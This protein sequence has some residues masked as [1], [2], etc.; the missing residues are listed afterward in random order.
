MMATRIH[1]LKEYQLRERSSLDALLDACRICHVGIVRDGDPV[2]IPT[3]YARVA[4]TLF[5]HGSTGSYWMRQIARG[6]RLCVSVTACDA[7]I[8]AR[9]TFESS[10]QYRSAVIF[11]TAVP[12]AG[13]EKLEALEQIVEHLIPGR[14]GEV[15]DSHKTEVNRTMVLAVALTEWSL[16]R[17]SSVP[18]DK[19]VDIVGDTW[20]GTVPINWSIGPAIPSPDLR[21]DV[22]VPA[23]IAALMN[24]KGS[25]FPL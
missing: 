8:V 16:K 2:V 3:A 22:P 25:S 21:D 15:R 6:E 9:S 5:L 11:G 4:D 10:F 24:T 12:L 13:R 14:T 18:K 7:F 17:S 23:S 1:R 20:A 19:E